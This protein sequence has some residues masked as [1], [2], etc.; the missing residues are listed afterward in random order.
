M[1]QAY[2]QQRRQL[3]NKCYSSHHRSIVDIIIDSGEPANLAEA[4]ESRPSHSYN[5]SP[6]DGLKLPEYKLHCAQLHNR[7][8]I[9]DIGL[10]G[11]K[12]MQSADLPTSYGASIRMCIAATNVFVSVCVHEHISKTSHTS[13]VQF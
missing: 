13:F 12:L 8:E 5:L 6:L 9:Y 3:D 4:P 11:V 2:H 7:M 1:I 10:H